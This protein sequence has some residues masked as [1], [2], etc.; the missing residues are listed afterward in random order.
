M[1]IDIRSQ[2]NR[3]VLGHD[4]GVLDSYFDEWLEGFGH[5]LLILNVKE[6]GLETRVISLMSEI[7]DKMPD[8]FFLDQSFPT[9]V[10]SILSGQRYSSLRVSEYESIDVL[11]FLPTEWVWMDSHTGDWSFINQEMISLQQN[12]IKFCL[13]SPELRGKGKIEDIHKLKFLMGQIGFKPNA[14]CTKSIH[15]WE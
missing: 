2:G 4:P 15:L 10:S 14:I 13:A 1:E 7:L 11:N 3:L 5:E 6:D 8:H 12:G 9:L